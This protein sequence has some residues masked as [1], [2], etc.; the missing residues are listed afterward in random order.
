MNTAS[1]CYSA[2]AG[3][4][5]EAVAA[6]LA[7]LAK[8]RGLGPQVRVLDVG[9]GPGR[10]FPQFRTLRWSVSAMEPNP[11]F[12]ETATQAALAAGYEAPCRAGFG[13]IDTRA[14]YDL[15]TAIND[16]FSHLLSG[17]E[18]AQALRH[19]FRALRPGG[20]LFVDVP[21]FLWI[22]KNYRTPPEFRSLV[23]GGEVI[24]KREHEIDFH[25]ATFT[26]IEKYRLL[27]GGSEERTEMRHVYAMTS[28]PELEHQLHL[29][30]FT[31]LESYGSYAARSAEPIRNGRIL[32]S[33]VRQA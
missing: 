30:G 28:V 20:A 25:A 12:H 9:C 29:T 5:A 4:G 17:E 2:I 21:N 23:P 7:W 26:T 31:D 24:L 13:E 1:E 10:M 3:G 19:V 8:H 16:S 14:A 22:L 11:D 15:I 6:F 27:R 18:R 33:A 32:I